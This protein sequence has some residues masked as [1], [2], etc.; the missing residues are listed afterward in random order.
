MKKVLFSL[1]LVIFCFPAFSQM[2]TGSVFA[3]ANSSFN[4]GFATINNIDSN[5]KNTVLTYTLNPKLGYFVKNRFGVGAGMEFASS[6]TDY[7][8]DSR[9]L[10]G[11]F[12]R[13]YVQYGS[14]IPFGELS[15]GYGYQ[16]TIII[17]LGESFKTKHSLLSAAA[18]V[19]TDFF[20]NE[21]IAVEAILK[22][23]YEKQKPTDNLLGEGHTVSGIAAFFGI[24]IFFE[25]I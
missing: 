1:F 20:F 11:P 14:L 8:R 13:Y 4:L 22:Y 6:P 9:L 24:V 2:N 25:S 12:S 5:D 3:A 7:G 17:S 21:K 18:G 23:Y 10:F 15:L 16:N 19:G